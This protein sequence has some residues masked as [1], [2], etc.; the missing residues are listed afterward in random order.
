[1]ITVGRDPDTVEVGERRRSKSGAIWTA[2]VLQRHTP[3]AGQERGDL[4]YVQAESAG[5]RCRTF[6]F[7]EWFRMEVTP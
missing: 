7:M 3:L 1:M 5:G 4:A 6:H 2:T